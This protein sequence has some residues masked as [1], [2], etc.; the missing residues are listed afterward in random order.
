MI[1]KA[2]LQY[3]LFLKNTLFNSLKSV[4]TKNEGG[5][6]EKGVPNTTFSV[7]SLYCACNFPAHVL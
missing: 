2:T 6:W 1:F 4:R 5:G 3:N 7:Q